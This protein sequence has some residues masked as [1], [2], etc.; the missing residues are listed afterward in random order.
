M[1]SRKLGGPDT[2][3]IVLTGV[4]M[5][6]LALSGTRLSFHTLLPSSLQAEIATPTPSFRHC[7]QRAPRPRGGPSI[8]WS[9]VPSPTIIPCQAALREQRER[10]REKQTDNMCLSLC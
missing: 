3:G 2:G 10:E 8:V 1:E 4:R 6:T 5:V 7:P 9:L